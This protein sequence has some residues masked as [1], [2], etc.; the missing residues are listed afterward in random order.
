MPSGA[1]LDR[2]PFLSLSAVTCRR[3][4]KK[5]PDSFLPCPRPPNLL[6]GLA[7]IPHFTAACRYSPCGHPVQDRVLF[8]L[9]CLLV[10]LV[11]LQRSGSLG[12]R[13]LVRLCS[14]S[15]RRVARENMNGKHTL[16]F[17]PKLA[18]S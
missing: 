6:K 11:K 9:V 16:L 3:C 2:A 13:P 12:L 1:T 7:V 18:H 5:P 14:T 15:K 8:S 4:G 17:N 10:R